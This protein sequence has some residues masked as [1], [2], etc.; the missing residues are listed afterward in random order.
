MPGVSNATCRQEPISDPAGRLEVLH[1]PFCGRHVRPSHSGSREGGL[2][3]RFVAIPA[4][5]VAGWFLVPNGTSWLAGEFHPPAKVGCHRRL[6][7]VWL[8]TPCGG[9]NAIRR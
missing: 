4:Y 2:A 9:P 8:R 7:R 1:D 6:V 3:L 5:V